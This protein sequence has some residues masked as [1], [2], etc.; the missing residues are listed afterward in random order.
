MAG[1]RVCEPCRERWCL[2]ICRRRAWG[3]GSWGPSP[4]CSQDLPPLP[5]QGSVH[6]WGPGGTFSPNAYWASGPGRPT[7]GAG[8]QVGGGESGEGLGHGP[9][10][11]P[12]LALQ[13]VSR[14]LPTAGS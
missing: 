13:G 11:S 14:R 6:E 5:L 10:V 7:P 3:Q 8:G 1:S 12:D 4:V 2:S 9:R